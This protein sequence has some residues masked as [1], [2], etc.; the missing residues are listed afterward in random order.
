MTAEGLAVFRIEVER[1]LAQM[2]AV[3][4]A[5]ATLPAML[6]LMKARGWWCGPFASP[7]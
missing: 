1:R 4:D 2:N 6:S 3:L 7:A 5:D